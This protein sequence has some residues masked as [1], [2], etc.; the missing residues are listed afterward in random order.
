MEKIS[1]IVPVYKVQD[2]LERCVDSILAQTWSALEVILVDDGSPDDCGAICDRYA[3]QDARVRVIHKANGGLSSARNAGMDAATGDWLAFVDSDDW[4][5]PTMLDLLHRLCV[6]HDA[7]IAE[8]GYRSFYA[9]RTESS[10]AETGTVTEATPLQAMEGNLDYK[11]F[12]VMV[13]NKLYR[14]DITR[15]VRFPEGR[16]HEDEFTTHKFYLA[17]QKIVAVDTAAYNYDR[18]REGSITAR[19]RAENLTDACAALRERMYLAWETPVLAPLGERLCNLYGWILFDRLVKCE[20][21]GIDLGDLRVRRT[22]QDALAD[23]PKMRQHGLAERYEENFKALKKRRCK[24]LYNGFER[25]ARKERAQGHALCTGK[26][27]Q[28]AAEPRRARRIAHGGSMGSHGTGAAQISGTGG[29]CSRKGHKNS[30]GARQR[31][32]C[33]TEPTAAK[34]SV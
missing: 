7:Q 4:L 29:R 25:A 1:V 6:E 18:S 34:Q 26:P 22:V 32:R 3:A 33:L 16:I 24:A 14:A 20:Q 5:D 28:R 10:A 12:F 17:A 11:R 27:G 15:G 31:E 21:A 8:C 30:D 2:Y 23:W 9:D 19:F 13:W